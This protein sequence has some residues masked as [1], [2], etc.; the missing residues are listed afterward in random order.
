M[1]DGVSIRAMARAGLRIYTRPV[2]HDLQDSYRM[3]GTA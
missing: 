3:R 1:R 2:N